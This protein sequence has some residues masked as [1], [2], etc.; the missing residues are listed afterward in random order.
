M[1]EVLNWPTS[2]KV[3]DIQKFLRLANYYWCQTITWPGK[4][5]LELE[6]NQE[7]EKGISGIKEE[8]HKETSV[9]STGLGQKNENRSGCI[10]LYDRENII[11]RVWG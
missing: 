2:K 7:I 5:G 1:K 9:S 10:G 8:V 6:L 11:Y 3:K 4:K